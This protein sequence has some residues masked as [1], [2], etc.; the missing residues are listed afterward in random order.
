MYLSMQA[1]FIVSEDKIK[2][3]CKISFFHA[4]NFLKIGDIHF[5]IELELTEV[6]N[7]FKK[8]NKKERKREKKK[9]ISTF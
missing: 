6:A 3:N 5:I 2:Y 4:V 7:L 8:K 1:C 9:G